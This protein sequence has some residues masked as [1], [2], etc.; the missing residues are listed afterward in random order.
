MAACTS[1]GPEYRF[2]ADQ[3]AWQPY[4]DGQVLRFGNSQTAAV[5]TYRVTRVLDIMEK[6][7]ALWG[8]KPFPHEGPPSYQNV[9]AYLQRTDSLSD[10]FAAF[11][12]DFDFVN[13]PVV[14][15]SEM[16]VNARLNWDT[17]LYTPS[18]AILPVD[19]LNQGLPLDTVRYGSVR[20]LPVH[21]LG[22][23]TYTAVVQY[24]L[25]STQYGGPT[26]GLY[27]TKANGVV[28]FVQRNALW[29]RIP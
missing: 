23:A 3:L 12:L 25:R 16:L 17:P 21:T 18:I 24:T 7:N 4:Q 28:G 20:L 2:T 26:T 9:S 10:E 5:R 15:G 27:L 6:Q 8:F 14:A 19:E 22:S 13:S 11:R 29:Y 1:P